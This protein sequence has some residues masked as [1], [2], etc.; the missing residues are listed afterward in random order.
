MVACQWIGHKVN[1]HPTVAWKATKPNRQCGPL[2]PVNNDWIDCPLTE[3]IEHDI[4]KFQYYCSLSIIEIHIF[5]S[6]Q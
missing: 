2:L 6:R 4:F 3:L 1:L 5:I